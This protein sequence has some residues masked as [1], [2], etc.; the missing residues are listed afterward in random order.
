MS[1]KIPY[2]RPRLAGGEIDNIRD[3][4]DR[5][6]LAGDG[7]YTFACQDEVLALTGGEACLLTHSCTAALEMAAIL[8]GLKPGDE[9]IV[10]SF[11]FVSTANAIV[12]RGAI[13]IFVDIRADTLNLD[14]GLVER[15]ITPR[16]RAIFAVH[17]AGVAA[18]MDVLARIA[19]AHRL[20]LVEDAAQAFGSTY[21][22]RK[23]GSL[24]ALAAFSFHETKNI[25]SGEGGAL[26]VNDPTML[27]RAEIIREKGTNRKQFSR[28]FTDKY[29]WVDIGSSYLPGELVAAYLYGQL[30]C[31]EEIHRDRMEVWEYYA[32]QLAPLGALGFELPRI[33]DHCRHNAHLFYVLAPSAE[34]RDQLIARMLEDGIATPFHYVPLHSSPA[35][36][37]F[38]RAPYPMP[39]TDELS[40]R[41]LRLPM[42]PKLGEERHEVAT[43]LLH[44]AHA[45]TRR[46]ASAE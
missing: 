46:R 10:P 14:E 2:N 22:G 9:V 37:R 36:R 7:Y 20:I 31:A 40:A 33:P 18:E 21:R 11:T 35:G 12:L 23:V 25:V 4:I 30:K 42:Y 3:A 8:C 45:L 6:Q 16:T 29:T 43:R 41:L 39:H 26:V 19:A 28:G 13:P 27:G 32:R 17:Y 24:A 5:R 15:L 1:I 38:G 34:M 44:H